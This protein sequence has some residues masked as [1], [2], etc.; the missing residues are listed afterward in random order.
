SSIMIVCWAVASP[1]CGALSDRVGRRKTIHASGCVIAT[2]GWILLFYAPLS[3]AAWVVVASVTSFASGSVVIGFAYAKES[4]PVRF[5]GT[6]SAA[7]N[8][9]N[10]VGPMIL[11]PGIGWLL[12]K[13]W[14]GT[15]VNGVRVYGVPAFHTAFLLVIGWLVLASIL[16]SLTRETHCKHTA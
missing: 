10:M 11:Q 7:V 12:D 4:V 8:I 3:L 9:G 14:A 6:I 2:I 5:L 15:M 13:K 16:L 1:I